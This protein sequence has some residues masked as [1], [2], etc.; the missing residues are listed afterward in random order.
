M[1]ADTLRYGLKV[2][3]FNYEANNSN[4]FVVNPTEIKMCRPLHTI[5]VY[6]NEN[7]HMTISR[8]LK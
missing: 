4:L 8:T 3:T 1:L 5:T 6:K 2:M 7:R